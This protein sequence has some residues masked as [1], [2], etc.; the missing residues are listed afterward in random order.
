MYSQPLLLMFHLL[1]YKYSN[2]KRRLMGFGSV[3]LQAWP[4]HGENETFFLQHFIV[5][6]HKI[7]LTDCQ[8]CE[9]PKQIQ[10]MV[11]NPQLSLLIAVFLSIQF[12]K[13]GFGMWFTCLGSQTL[14]TT[15]SHRKS[16]LSKTTQKTTYHKGL[17][18]AQIC[19]YQFLIEALP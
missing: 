9:N 5:V 8:H 11:F 12:V 16:E 18:I 13:L 7:K 17:L 10:V 15:V 14:R 1:M 19:K 4:Y 2:T 6:N 3:E